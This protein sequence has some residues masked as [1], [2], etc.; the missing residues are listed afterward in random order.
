[1][2]SSVK[3]STSLNG[4]EPQEE[5]ATQGQGSWM[6]QAMPDGNLFYLDT[7]TGDTITELP[8]E[9]AIS[10]D[11]TRLYEET[12][13]PPPLHG[14]SIQPNA[15]EPKKFHRVRPTRGRSIWDIPAGGGAYGNIP[16]YKLVVLGDSV[17]TTALT[18]QVR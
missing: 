16:L 5:I 2:E 9:T 4:T 7:L 18:I 13:T 15:V 14:Q 1:L 10:A 8:L 6:L 12:A 17:D 3:A 11:E